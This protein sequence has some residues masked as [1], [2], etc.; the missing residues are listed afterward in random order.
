MIIRDSFAHL[1]VGKDL[2]LRPGAVQ[3]VTGHGLT[4]LEWRRIGPLDRELVL[5]VY[6]TQHAKGPGL[7]QDLH[8][9][10]HG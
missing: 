4:R 10:R 3:E 8:D 1:E 9:V 5:G 7:L 6:G 2:G